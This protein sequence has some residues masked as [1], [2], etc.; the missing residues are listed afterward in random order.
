MANEQ[1]LVCREYGGE[2]EGYFYV[3]Y[4]LRDREG[5]KERE[6]RNEERE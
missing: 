4:S 6:W 2:R 5:E 1:W 3:E